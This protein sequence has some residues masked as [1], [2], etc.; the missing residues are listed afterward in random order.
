MF[1]DEKRAIESAE[2]NPSL[3]F[4]LISEG[5]K[6]TVEKIIKRKK[7]DINTLN[8]NNSDIAT[9]LLKKGWY[10]LTLLV[11]KDKSWNINHQ[12]KDGDTFAHILVTKKYLDV[13]DIIKEL[14]KNNEFIPNI[15][16]NKG[17]TILDKSINDN[18]I[19]TTVKI[20]EDERF[21]NIDL[22]SFQNLYNN[23]IKS[24]KYG[25]Y[26]KINNLE[27][28][29]E[30]LVEKELLP[31]LNKLVVDI[32]R[33]IKAIKKDVE[34]NELDNLDALINSVIYETA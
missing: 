12:N 32:K 29:I 20:L 15:R 17:E 3:I 24:N 22:V 31:K 11:M 8:D 18:Y 30:N 9:Y 34:N 19:Y 33:N 23:Y 1:Y 16:N 28:I 10:D 7:V 25:K 13:I 2:D 27:I 6:D 26:S 4:N 14:L 21:N 5:H